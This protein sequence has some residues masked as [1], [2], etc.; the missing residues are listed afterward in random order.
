MFG[1]DD[2]IANGAKL[3]DDIVTRIW[4]DAT[5]VEKAKLAQVT[6]QIQN[7]YSL[8]LQQLKINEAE[9]QN[10][11]LFVAG[12]RPAVIW[13]GVASLTYTGLLQPLLGWVA[14]CFGWPLPPVPTNEALN[15]LLFGLLGIGGMRTAEKLKGVATRG[16]K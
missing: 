1:I 6:Q 3:I 5:E 13:V 11:H 8:V 15:T 12:G 14:A 2:A 16:L 7:E 4:P 9:A 10:P